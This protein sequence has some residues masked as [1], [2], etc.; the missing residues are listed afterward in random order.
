MFLKYSDANA[1]TEGLYKVPEL[2]KWLDFGR[3]TAKVYSLDLLSG[4]S[5]PFAKS[6]LSKVKL[7][8][9]AKTDKVKRK[10]VDGKDT[11]I[12][13]FSASQEARLGNVHDRR[14]QNFDVL[15]N[16]KDSEEMHA[17]MDRALPSDSGIV[18][19]HIGGDF[20][21]EQYFLAWLMLAQS[22]PE[23]LF[24]AYTKSLRYWLKNMALVN[25]LDNVVLTASRGGREDFLIDKHNLREAIVVYSEEQAE[26][27]GLP[28]D[29]DDSHA[30][31]NG[32]S[33]ALLVHGTQPAGSE[34]AKA[35]VK[36]RGKGSYSR[37]KVK[38]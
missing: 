5:C 35:L 34:A 6:C 23:T 30:A 28:I 4:H 31:L 19:Q 25:S 13:C 32:G 38:A 27:L 22:H 17:A 7:S 2:K 3:F 36:L 8:Y 16:C 11:E 29:H 24:Y 10:V 37:K 14:K 1:K 20:F 18:R 15:R 12:R 21:N 9:D 33:F 26:K